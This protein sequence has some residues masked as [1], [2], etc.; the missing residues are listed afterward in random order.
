MY[1]P[2]VVSQTAM[3]SDFLQSFQVLADLAVEHVGQRLRVLAVLH[4]LLPVEEP[5]RNLVLARVR[6]HRYHLFHLV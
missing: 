3:S 1:R 2:P 5:V 4:V 6:H